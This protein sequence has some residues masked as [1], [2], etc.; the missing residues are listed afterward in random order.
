MIRAYRLVKRR[1]LTTAFDGEGARRYGGRWNTKGQP[2]IYLTSSISLGHLEIMVH[3]TDYHVL[4]QYAVLSL[5]LET[6]DIMALP[7]DTLP[8]DWRGYPAPLSTAAIGDEWLAGRESA[9]LS[10]PSVIVPTE[11]NYLLNPRH[12]EFT[13]IIETAREVAFSFDPRLGPT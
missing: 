6:K 12:P 5:D 8:D 13:A 1:L 10:V 9:I 7:D 4:R 11:R 2:C 3:L